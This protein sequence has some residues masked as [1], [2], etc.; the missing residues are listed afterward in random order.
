M[1]DVNDNAPQF[2]YEG[3]ASSELVTDQ[4]LVAIPDATSVG[5]VI[6]ALKAEDADSGEFG[7]VSYELVGDDLAEEYFAVDGETGAVTTTASFLGSGVQEDDLPFELIVV[8]RDNPN[9]I[10][11]S[12]T[13]K[14]MLVVTIKDFGLVLGCSIITL[15]PQVN[16]L[17]PG[18]GIVLKITDTPPSEMA[19]KKPELIALMQQQTGLVVEVDRMLPLMT[20]K[21]IGTQ[22]QARIFHFISCKINYRHKRA[23]ERINVSCFGSRWTGRRTPRHVVT[24]IPLELTSTST[25]W[26]LPPTRSCLSTMRKYRGE[27]K[28]R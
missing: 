3:E 19:K 21:V 23:S 1:A 14:T 6:F 18:D 2:V 17:R 25:S 15:L 4:Y 9:D 11:N 22:L 24:S 7:R 28:F 10:D 16:L 13:Q 5:A 12:L 20:L 26:I 27:A 8:A